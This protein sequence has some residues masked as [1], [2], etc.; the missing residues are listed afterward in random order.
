MSRGLMK[1]MMLA[2]LAA[3]TR[4]EDFYRDPMLSSRSQS[5]P[6]TKPTMSEE[7]KKRI[8]EAYLR[9]FHIFNINGVEISAKS[10]KD[11]KK[12]YERRKRV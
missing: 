4:Y 1:M 10:K 6:S 2:G 5:S 11:A 8:H 7:D 3:A 9:Q 12:I